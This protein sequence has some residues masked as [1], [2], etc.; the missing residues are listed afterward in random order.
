MNKIKVIVTGGAGRMGTMTIRTILDQANMELIGAV[1]V[2]SVGQDAG[3]LAG[4]QP[5]GVNI[6]DDI[7]KILKEKSPEVMVDFSQGPVAGD[8]ILAC[9]KAGVACV[10]GTTGIDDEIL[11]QVEI[12]SL[13]QGVPV[14]LAPNFSVGAVLMMQFASQAAQHMK[15]GEIIELHHEKKADAPSGTALRTARMMSDVR[16]SFSQTADEIEK[17][18]GARGGVYN[19]IHIHS[20]R[21]PGLLAHQEVRLGATGETLTIR[22]DSI[23]RECFM[24]GVMLAVQKVK[25]LR[26]LV[27]GLENVM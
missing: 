13:S 22:H 7:H 3:T 2:T 14:L 10:V 1:D 26:G 6:T 23:S 16:G 12:E 15:W 19:G 20:V 18:E 8:N 25:N 4:L 24:P 9:I 21:M 11:R 17:L 5:C 27:V